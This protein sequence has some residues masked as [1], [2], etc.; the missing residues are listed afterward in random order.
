[1]FFMSLCLKKTT[2]PLK[3]VLYV[4]MSYKENMSFMS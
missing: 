4:F 2:C 3:Y 1:M